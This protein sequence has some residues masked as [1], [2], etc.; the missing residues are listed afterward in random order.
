MEFKEWLGIEESSGSTRQRE[1]VYPPEADQIFSRSTDVRTIDAFKDKL[2]SASSEEGGWK[3]INVEPESIY[4]I[5]YWTM[6]SRSLPDD[7]GWRHKEDADQL[8]GAVEVVKLKDLAKQA[9]RSRTLP[10]GE[11][12]G[13]WWQHHDDGQKSSVEIVRE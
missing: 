12:L 5:P 10:S 9:V 6:Q 7:N 3:L 2:K 8:Q 13:G 1:P 4:K 11:P